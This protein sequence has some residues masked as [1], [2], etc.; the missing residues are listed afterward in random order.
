MLNQALIG[1]ISP[2]F[3]LVELDYEDGK[4][5]VR[6]ILAKNDPNDR[7]EVGEIV[8]AMSCYLE[9]IRDRISKDAYAEVSSDVVVSQEI[10]TIDPTM[11]GRVVFRMRD[12]SVG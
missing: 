4:W 7:D 2:N 12:S 10:I 8:D 5:V 1:S 3:R 11:E 6:V 9:D